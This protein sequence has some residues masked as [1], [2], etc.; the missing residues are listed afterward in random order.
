MRWR[1]GGVSADVEDRR[2]SG[3]AGRGLKLGIGGTL[4][5]GLLS[6]L[7]GTDL[8]AVIGGG[9]GVPT[10]GEQQGAPVSETPAERE[11]VEFVS[12]VLDDLQQ[13]WSGEFSRAGGDY[14][15]AKLVLFRDVVDSACGTGQSAT[16]PFY[17]PLDGKVYLDLGFFDELASRFGAAGEFA[18]AYVVAHEMGHHVQN[19][20]G[21][22]DKVR[23]LQSRRPGERNAL[24]VRLELQAD[25]LA[26]VWAHSTRRRDLL[27][28]GD[29]E[30]A[31]GAASAIGD[32]RL[33][34]GAG[35]RVS[36]E[37]F[38]HGSSAER[39]EWF[40]RGLESGRADGC[41]T[42]GGS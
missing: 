5:V 13:T 4:V 33:Q 35:R 36:P 17:C 6:M 10:G 19:L 37:T 38:T 39:V 23:A 8:F 42:F 26:G 32:D 7:L 16:G 30:S 22:S 29:V 1:R 21:V 15:R 24:S 3:F 40:R 41:D 31:L 27:E 2:G 34:R 9:S 20:L 18:Q 25:C 12:F 11:R 14:Q 28:R